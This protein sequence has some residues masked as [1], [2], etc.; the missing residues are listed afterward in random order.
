MKHV[1]D[2]PPF[3]RPGI[4]P[5]RQLPRKRGSDRP[6]ILGGSSPACGGGDREAIGGGSLPKDQLR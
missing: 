6:A 3:S 1:L 2:S 4:I 5:G